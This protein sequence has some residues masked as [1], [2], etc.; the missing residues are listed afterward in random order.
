MLKNGLDHA[1]GHLFLNFE[2]DDE[3]RCALED[4]EIDDPYGR[5]TYSFDAD[6]S[7]WTDAVR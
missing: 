7:N 2:S 6:E 1:L 3:F 4:I 5:P